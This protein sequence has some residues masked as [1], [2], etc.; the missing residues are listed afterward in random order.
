[1]T[2]P[3]P[4]PE[5]RRTLTVRPAEHE[6][7]LG[8]NSDWHAAA[9]TDWLIETGM[10]AF[11]VWAEQNRGDYGRTGAIMNDVSATD[12]AT[13]VAR[14]ILEQA[15]ADVCMYCGDRA[16]GWEAANGPNSAGNWIHANLNYSPPQVVLC[17]A[18]AIH[19]RKHFSGAVDVLA[20]TIRAHA[21]E[22]V[23]EVEKKIEAA[24]QEGYRAGF[25]QGVEDQMERE[26]ELREGKRW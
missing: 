15:A 7:F 3:I 14:Q 25:K 26:R 13:D 1:V 6:V 21:D 20:A 18:S 16:V 2:L 22:A 5:I 8:F 23:R 10:E 9:F 4:L 12:G 24:R 11:R 19:V 17:A